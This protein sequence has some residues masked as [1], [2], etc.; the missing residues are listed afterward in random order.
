MYI[1]LFYQVYFITNLSEEHSA[2]VL[3]LPHTNA[4]IISLMMNACLLKHVEVEK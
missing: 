1:L 4:N 3:T 2:Y